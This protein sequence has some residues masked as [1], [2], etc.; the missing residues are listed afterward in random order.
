MTSALSSWSHRAWL[1]LV[2]AATLGLLAG[3][4]SGD[5]PKA[6]LLGLVQGE[7]MTFTM[8]P[9]NRLLSII[10]DN[11]ILGV[12]PRPSIKPGDP[13]T[14]SAGFTLAFAGPPSRARFWIRGFT[15]GVSSRGSLIVSGDGTRLADLTAQVAEGDFL[16]CFDMTMRTPRKPVRWVVAVP[17]PPDGQ[18][19]AFHVDSIDIGLLSAG[20]ASLT[21]GRCPER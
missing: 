14:M 12:S 1:P 16:A 8:S 17:A 7:R 15:A 2:L 6:R 9:D 3:A 13:L 10:Y 11:A 21:G 5:V 19:V 18:T 20:A 4:A